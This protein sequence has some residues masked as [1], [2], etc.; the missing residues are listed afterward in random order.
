M[1]TADPGVFGGLPG[2]VGSGVIPDPA[3]RT[4]IEIDVAVLA[5]AEPG[6]SR[7]ILA[8]GEAKW[9]RVMDLREIE[10]L[11]RARDLLAVKGFDTT[12]TT[13]ACFSSAGFSPELRA[14]QAADIRLIGLDQLYKG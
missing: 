11:R 1:T 7:R 10:R 3:H 5:P 8:L 12:D 14:A 13:L 2:E 9:D 4:Q 6:R